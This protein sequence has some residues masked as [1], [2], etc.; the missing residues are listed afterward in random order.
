M[1][2]AALIPVAVGGKRRDQIGVDGAAGTK[3]RRLSTARSPVPADVPPVAAAAE[4]AVTVPSVYP[5]PPPNPSDPD[6]EA[7]TLLFG[8]T[9][10]GAG[11]WKCLLRAKVTEENIVDTLKMCVGHMQV[12]HNLDTE[13]GSWLRQHRPAAKCIAAVL[14]HNGLANYMKRD[15]AFWATGD[16]HTPW[17]HV[18]QW[19]PLL[20]LGLLDAA[21]N[22][23]LS[24]WQNSLNTTSVYQP[25]TPS[26]TWRALLQTMLARSSDAHLNGVPTGDHPLL[27]AAKSS[28]WSLTESYPLTELERYVR[29]DGSGIV[30][31][32]ELADETARVFETAVDEPKY[33]PRTRI[34]KATA[35]RIRALSERCT[36]YRNA[37]GGALK[38]A[39]DNSIPIAGVLQLID[40]YAIRRAPPTG[41]L[42]DSQ[43]ATILSRTRKT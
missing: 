37:F 14:L 21:P 28:I 43:T 22:V 10:F 23:K 24:S 33:Q 31:T 32:D 4:A 42:S 13:D 12:V 6:L 15:F 5:P 7:A 27:A 38:D 25:V 30:L 18:C 20:A 17:E 40:T 39:L 11:L 16:L 8:K 36:A 34:Y 26:P 29:E 3:R 1:A 9:Q 19:V 41:P 35:A 2:A